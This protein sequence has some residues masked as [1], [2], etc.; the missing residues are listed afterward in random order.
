MYQFVIEINTFG[1]LISAFNK[2]DDD[3]YTD[4]SMLYYAK[5]T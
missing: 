1:E 2:F 4:I 5:Y 3:T